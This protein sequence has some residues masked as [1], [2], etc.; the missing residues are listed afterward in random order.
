MK[1]RESRDAMVARVN[2]I[3]AKYPAFLALPEVSNGEIF[4]TLPGSDAGAYIKSLYVIC[5]NGEV[6]GRK[7]DAVCG[8]ALGDS[9]VLG[10]A[11]MRVGKAK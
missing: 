10:E 7:G 11:T 3:Y 2:A 5:A 6:T 4:S 8:K 9:P 1:D